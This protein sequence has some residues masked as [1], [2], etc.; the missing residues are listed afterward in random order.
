MLLIEELSDD[1]PD[2]HDSDLPIHKIRIIASRVLG[3]TE[4]LTG[5]P[6]LVTMSRMDYYTLLGLAVGGPYYAEAK[7]S[8]DK[9][10]DRVKARNG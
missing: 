4:H 8:I 9:I 3:E 5:D 2:Q 6:S 7:A 10:I 1:T